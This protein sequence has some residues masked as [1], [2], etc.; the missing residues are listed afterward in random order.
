MFIP[1]VGT[2][3]HFVLAEEVALSLCAQSAVLTAKR[4]AEE[5]CRGS[6]ALL[7]LDCP[8]CALWYKK[9]LWIPLFFTFMLTKGE[10]RDQKMPLKF[11][12]IWKKSIESFGSRALSQTQDP[13][14]QHPGDPTCWGQGCRAGLRVSSLHVFNPFMKFSPWQFQTMNEMLWASFKEL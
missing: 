8:L 5:Q 9:K 14:G 6:L 2:F 3:L 4:H 12:S 10:K 13:D 7:N 1:S 11:F